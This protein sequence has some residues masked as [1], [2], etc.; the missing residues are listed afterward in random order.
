MESKLNNGIKSIIN[1]FKISCDKIKLLECNEDFY[2]QIQDVLKSIK[3]E[4]ENI[5][6]ATE[7]SNLN[8][9][10]TNE[11]SFYLNK[12]GFSLNDLPNNSLLESAANI[13]QETGIYDYNSNSLL[14]KYISMIEVGKK[15]KELVD[16]IDEHINKLKTVIDQQ[17]D[18][19]FELSNK[20][21]TP[22]GYKAKEINMDLVENVTIDLYHE[23]IIELVRKIDD[24]ETKDMAI[25][26]EI[27]KLKSNQ[28]KIYYGLPPNMD[29]TMIAVKMAEQTLK[30]IS[31]QIIE[32]LEKK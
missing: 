10:I 27:E 5:D 9:S 22:I 21:Y 13:L 1:D 29:Q 18:L 20:T 12:I 7:I 32:K 2:N 4:E 6:Y 24:I 3:N 19:K 17:N 16:N 26:E 14:N 25:C 23:K 31:K 28:K 11:Q 30:S 8:E 15:K